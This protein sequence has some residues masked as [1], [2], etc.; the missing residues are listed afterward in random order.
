[1]RMMGKLSVIGKV[2]IKDIYYCS[3]RQSDHY[4]EN[5]IDDTLMHHCK[6]G[7]AKLE[8]KLNYLQKSR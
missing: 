6:G 3:N 1:M 2:H 7:N 8:K 5:I 4:L